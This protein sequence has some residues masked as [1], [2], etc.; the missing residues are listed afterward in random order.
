LSMKQIKFEVQG[1][2]IGKARPRVTRNGNTY[3]PA[4][5]RLYENAI[6]D[7]FIKAGGDKLSG[8]LHVDYEAVTGIQ[9]SATKRD[10]AR[11]LSGQELST[12]KPD[13]DNI[14]KAL[15]D[16]LNGV[17]YADDASVVSVRALKGRYE[18]EP[19]LI[20][21][22]REIDPEEVAEIH[23]WMWGI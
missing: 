2:V 11:R 22:V 6:R 12:S 18:L 10:R 23:G 4:R 1:K 20:V 3:T 19:R 15:L 17:A 9:A 13:I 14:E 5:T 21:R 8:T 16:A 7:A